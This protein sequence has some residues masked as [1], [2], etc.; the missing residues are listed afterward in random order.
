MIKNYGEQVV[1]EILPNILKEFT[2]ICKCQKCINDIKCI[3][4]NNLK[5][6]Y[7][8]SDDEVGSIF[9]KLKSL[10]IQYKTYVINE[11]TKAIKIVSQKPRHNPR[12]LHF[13]LKQSVI[14]L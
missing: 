4:L 6:S 11:A 10:Q 5:L 8:A 1:E 14:T 12:P 2:D 9:F 7:F 13:S 3:T